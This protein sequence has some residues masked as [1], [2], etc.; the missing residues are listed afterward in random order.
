MHRTGW[1]RTF[2]ALTVV[3][4]AT[5]P[6][7]A[8]TAITLGQ[9][10]SGEAAAGDRTLTDGKSFDCW[11]LQTASGRGYYVWA[12]STVLDTYL[13]IGPGGDCSAGVE[14]ASGDDGAGG[15]DAA[16]TL[17]GDGQIWFIRV[18]S[19]I[20]GQVG[21]Y[22]L[23]VTPSADGWNDEAACRDRSAAPTWRIAACNRY[24]ANGALAG[25]AR[26]DAY[27][28]RA[29]AYYVQKNYAAAIVGYVEAERI[30]PTARS[31]HA[32]D[33]ALAL[34]NQ[35]ATLTALDQQFLYYERAIAMDPTQA[36]PYVGRAHVYRGWG[37]DDL[38]LQDLD[39]ALTRDPQLVAALSIRARIRGEARNYALARADYDQMIQ[40]NSNN[41]AAHWGR[42][43][44]FFEEK[45]FAEALPSLDHALRLN[46]RNGVVL[47]MRGVAR[48]DTGNLAG[49]VEDLTRAHGLGAGDLYSWD[50]LGRA[51]YAQG[52][53]QA[54][55]GAYDQAL[56][57]E[58]SQGV[59]LNNRLLAQTQLAQAQQLAARQRQQEEVRRQCL[60][61][62]RQLNQEAEQRA[63]GNLLTGLA[64]AATGNTAYAQQQLGQA[65]TGRAMDL[66][67]R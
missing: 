16:L 53:Y 40:I 34:N 55:I 41:E 35:G 2:A 5:S 56:T 66:G 24:I 37:L 23:A 21:P 49:G 48:V 13:Q 25:P 31:R 11:T 18:V 6:A 27:A 19:M 63:M 65:A 67:C 62:Q 12:G 29:H 9:T 3:T 50:A 30:D 44:T 57:F 33:H 4:T 60:A 10:L 1:F 15:R 64:G 38:A 20:R 7:M 32:A 43:W 39:R 46:P 17:M 28:A 58:P 51:Y 59:V 22:T 14:Q 42:G 36:Y 61:R 54:A 47:R 26:A 52:L 45:R 8:Q